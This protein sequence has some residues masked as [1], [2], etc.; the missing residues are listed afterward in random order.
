MLLPSIMVHSY[1]IFFYSFSFFHRFN[2]LFWKSNIIIFFFLRP[3]VSLCYVKSSWHTAMKWKQLLVITL[4]HIFIKRYVSWILIP[5]IHAIFLSPPL[6]PITLLFSFLPKEG[7]ILKFPC[8]SVWVVNEVLDS[9]MNM[10]CYWFC[11]CLRACVFVCA[12]L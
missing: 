11:V 6:S 1:S 2:I 7:G 4:L 12:C 9:I 10:Q 3:D 5:H 8:C